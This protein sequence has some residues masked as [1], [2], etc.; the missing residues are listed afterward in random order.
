LD[1]DQQRQFIDEL[2]L[3][4]AA[5]V[6][7][8]MEPDEAGALL[9]TADQEK[10]TLIM[11]LLDPDMRSDIA[12]IDSYSDDQIGSRMTTN[13]V[14]VPRGCNVKEA[15]RLLVQQAPDNDNIST[16]YVSDN[17][18]YAG[19]V[20]LKDLIIARN[21]TPLEDIV[22]ASF[23]Y[24]YGTESTESV[25]ESLKD[26]NEDSIPVLGA[27]NRILGVIT[28]QDLMEVMDEEMGEDYAKLAG[29]MAEEDL[30]ETLFDSLKKRLPWLFFLLAL[31]MVVSW[32]VSLFEGVVAAVPLV[33]AF[34]SLILGMS[35]NAGTQSLAVTIRVLMDDELTAKD[36]WGLVRKELRVGFTN[37]LILGFAAFVLLGLYI[38]L[39]KHQTW[40]HAYIISGCIGLSLWLAMIISSL[41][42]TSIP[43]FFK[44]IGVDPAVASGPLITTV[45]DL[46]AVITYYSLVYVLLIQTAGL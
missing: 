14:E 20:D 41:T 23:P 8:G 42:G 26:Y 12:L 19:A 17:H 2:T 18:I 27:D 16:I 32:T 6:L 7:N 37:G 25:I 35:G 36:K 28:V 4:K 9:E 3:K 10:Q 46:A 44:K 34:Q 38:A 29:L 21:E 39:V 24:V 45:N 33:M 13:F 22:T 11:E 1:E 31:G 40:T 15:M 5:Q 30:E 43:I